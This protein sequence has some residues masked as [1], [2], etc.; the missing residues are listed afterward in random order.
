[1]RIGDVSQVGLAVPR[2]VAGR[3][4]YDLRCEDGTWLIAM[5]T[6]RLLTREL[7]QFNLTFV[8]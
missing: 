3:C 5:K 6:V 8:I 1:V 4:V 2:S 7:P